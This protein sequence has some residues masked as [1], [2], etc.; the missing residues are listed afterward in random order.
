[1]SSGN[2]SL[3]VQKQAELWLGVSI[4]RP[5]RYGSIASAMRVF[6]GLA[7]DACLIRVPLEVLPRIYR[8]C[9]RYVGVRVCHN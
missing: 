8:R 5:E 6:L 4:E 9:V 2:V 7:H 1:M 3:P